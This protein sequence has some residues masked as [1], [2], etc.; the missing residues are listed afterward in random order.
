[1]HNW[2]IHRFDPQKRHQS[3]FRLHKLK[4][5]SWSYRDTD[6]MKQLHDSVVH[7]LLWAKMTQKVFS[8]ILSIDQNNLPTGTVTKCSPISTQQGFHNPLKAK[9]CHEI[10]DQLQKKIS[11]LQTG[12]SG[13]KLWLGY[14][15][16]FIKL[17][18]II[19]PGKKWLLLFGLDEWFWSDSLFLML[20]FMADPRGLS[21]VKSTE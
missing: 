14:V 16:W 2:C 17:H 19:T 13:L 9:Q 4:W 15:K 8:G 6:P 12:I 10:A 21:T 3:L 5:Y 11:N 20:W 1:M 18:I 7:L